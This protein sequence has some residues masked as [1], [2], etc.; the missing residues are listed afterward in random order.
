M[1][2]FAL[3]ACSLQ[4][5]RRTVQ[6]NFEAGYVELRIVGSAAPKG[7]NSSLAMLQ[8]VT[9]ANTTIT[10]N[11]AMEVIINSSLPSVSLAGGC[12]YLSYAKR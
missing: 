3:S 2:L 10:Q 4:I 8:P 9:A 11:P 1:T 5:V 7:V 12:W 6:D